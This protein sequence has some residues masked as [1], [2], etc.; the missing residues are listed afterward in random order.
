MGKASIPGKVKTRLVP[1]LTPDEAVQF[2]TAF[3]QDMV[4]NIEAAARQVDVSPCIAY[5]PAG[6]ED[7]FRALLP[8][9]VSLLE[10]ALGNFGDCLYFTIDTLLERGFGSVCVLNSDSPTL[11]TAALIEAARAL[12]APG[13][14]AVLGPCLD[15]G[16]YLLGLKQP[17]RHMFER[18]DWST[19]RVF[20]QTRERAAEIG[21]PLVLLDPW[22]DVDDITALRRLRDE[23]LPAEPPAETA[24]R[25]PPA[26][27]SEAAPI[28]AARHARAALGRMLQ[29]QGLAQRLA[30]PGAQRR[31][32]SHDAMAG[33]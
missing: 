28:H 15:G 32:A 12:A 24:P 9:R 21:L 4:D 19:E 16:Y 33:T 31:S 18:I 20:D 8:S 23:L 10:C 2:N 5:G 26:Q 3:L 29:E 27:C 11:P 30:E 25:A 14:R 6:S 13:D 1:P 22:Y 17:H 7:F